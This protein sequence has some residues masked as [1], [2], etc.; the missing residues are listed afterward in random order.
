MFLKKR[1]LTLPGFI[2]GRDRA[3]GPAASRFQLL[4]CSE[5]SAQTLLT[6]H[7]HHTL[8]CLGPASWPP[9]PPISP[10]THSV[11]ASLTSQALLIPS[12]SALEEHEE[13]IELCL[14]FGTV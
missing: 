1:T 10:W 7:D 6:I 11:A 12:L 3:L 14:G 9:S 13:E 8:P 2:A 4:I 5:T